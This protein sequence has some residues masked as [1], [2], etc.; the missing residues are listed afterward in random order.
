M[1]ILT[2]LLALFAIYALLRDGSFAFVGV[3]IIGG[4]IIA[5]IKIFQGNASG[6]QE[7]LPNAKDESDPQSIGNQ[8][9]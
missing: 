3:L 9:K 7:K 8:D 1:K 4:A 6:Q 5:V 2:W